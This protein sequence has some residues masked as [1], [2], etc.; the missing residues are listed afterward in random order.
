[1]E[2]GIEVSIYIKLTLLIQ[3][4]ILYLHGGLARLTL[5]MM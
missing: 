1:M 4:T 3:P 2:I 5:N